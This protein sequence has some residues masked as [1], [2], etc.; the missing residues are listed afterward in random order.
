MPKQWNLLGEGVYNVVYVNAEKNQVLKI[1]KPHKTNTD[2]PERAVRLWN[3][4]NPD[5]PAA[6]RHNSILGNG[7]VSPYIA[8][9]QADDE[10]IQQS[11]IHIFHTTGRIVV[12][13]PV[14]KNFITTPEGHTVCV[15]IGFAL[16]LQ[17]NDE[18]PSATL[19]RVKSEDS[20]RTWER[21][22]KRFTHFF[23]KSVIKYPISTETIKALLFIN[24]NRPD[25][26]NVDFLIKD[27]SVRRHCA[28]AYS[29]S[30]S[31]PSQESI[32]GSQAL[33]LLQSVR[34]IH[35]PKIKEECLYQ[36]DHYIESRGEINTDARFIPN[37]TSKLFRSA[38]LTLVKVD[39]VKALKQSLL[40]ANTFDEMQ[41]HLNDIINDE[42]AVKSKFNSHLKQHIKR[43]LNLVE[44][45]KKETFSSEEPPQLRLN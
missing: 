7:W 14:F 34:P 30:L 11:L 24:K 38:P 28:T 40:K 31:F 23:N 44:K 41:T 25:I 27:P 45:G 37:C 8:G 33:E 16:Q 6:K 10:E 35:L 22:E 20:L 13:A 43:C 29:R 15:D 4:L 39:K 12:D 42:T 19:V 36:L 1:P 9:R 5:F 17:K 18:A 2:L 21:L 3:L 26:T 32:I